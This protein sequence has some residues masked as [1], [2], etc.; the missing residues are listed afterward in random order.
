[1]HHFDLGRPISFD[2]FRLPAL[3]QQIE[4]LQF[5]LGTSLAAKGK[6]NWA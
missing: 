2:R 1:L 6:R 3:E 5:A 4:R